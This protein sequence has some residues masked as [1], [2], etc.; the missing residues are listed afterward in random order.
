MNSRLLNYAVPLE[1]LVHE[2][3]K[4]MHLWRQLHR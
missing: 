2:V 4:A 1:A 3:G